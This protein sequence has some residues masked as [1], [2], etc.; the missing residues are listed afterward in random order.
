MSF[1]FHTNLRECIQEALEL[2]VVQS[3]A[4]K[5]KSIEGKKT[6]KSKNRRH[7]LEGYLYDEN[8]AASDMDEFINE[9]MN[10]Q[11]NFERSESD[12]TYYDHDGYYDEHSFQKHYDYNRD[13]S[14]C[15][16]T[17]SAVQN[18]HSTLDHIAMLEPHT[19]PL[20]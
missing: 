6:K 2:D 12:V 20:W 13:L 18:L 3:T 1:L 19:Q 7:L 10:D 5:G 4:V 11:N 17:D 16:A 9:Y 15:D 8:T 14:T